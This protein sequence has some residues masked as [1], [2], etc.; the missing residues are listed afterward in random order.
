MTL[1]YIPDSIVILSERSESKNLHQISVITVV[2]VSTA[3]VSLITL[4]M[5][6]LYIPGSIVILSEQSE[7]KNPHKLT[8][9]AAGQTI[10]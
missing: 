4:N 9:T 6:L 5:T 8:S 7:S 2:N 1:L 3:F 10:N